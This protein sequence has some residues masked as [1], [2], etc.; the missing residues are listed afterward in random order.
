[1]KQCCIPYNVSLADLPS[2]IE[3]DE[4][5]YRT[6]HHSDVFVVVK[7]YICDL[8]DLVLWSISAAVK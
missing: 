3:L 2:E 7:Q 5:R 8:V 4:A 1:M 6:S